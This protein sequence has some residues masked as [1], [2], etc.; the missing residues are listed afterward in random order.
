MNSWWALTRVLGQDTI[1]HLPGLGC[2]P[3]AEVF[4]HLAKSHIRGVT[5]LS[6]DSRSSCHPQTRS[7]ALLL[8]GNTPTLGLLR[9][10]AHLINTTSSHLSQFQFVSPVASDVGDHTVKS[11]L[12]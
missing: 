10:T 7:P 6:G 5:Q 2:C 3:V 1:G 12:L 4:G 11:F 8:K 9:S